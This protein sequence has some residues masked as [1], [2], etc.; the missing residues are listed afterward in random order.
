MILGLC[1][2]IAM[3]F[4]A[5]EPEVMD[6]WVSQYESQILTTAT[7]EARQGWKQLPED[8][9]SYDAY[10]AV[11][12][13]DLIGRHGVIVWTDYGTVESAIVVDCS[14]HT[15]T[16][17]WMQ[18]NNIIMEVDHETAKRHGF[19]GQGGVRAVLKLL[20]HWNEYGQISAVE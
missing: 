13:C 15:S 7:I 11:L 1:V 2:A 8:V 16:T 10:I 17:D 4:V 20:P 12:D 18:A 14:G 9:S 19:V 5:E 6:G 3:C